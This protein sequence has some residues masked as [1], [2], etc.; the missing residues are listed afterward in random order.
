[1]A[2]KTETID[3]EIFEATPIYRKRHEGPHIGA[4]ILIFLGVIFLFTNLGYLS[5]NVWNELWKFWPVIIILI[6]L[7]IFLGRS[8]LARFLITVITLIIF[9]IIILYVLYASGYYLPGTFPQNP[10]GF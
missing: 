8:A 3:E 10:Y 1:M 2:K 9:A 5:A 7:K 6:G 4:I